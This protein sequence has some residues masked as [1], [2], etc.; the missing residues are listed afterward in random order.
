MEIPP[1]PT[2]ATGLRGPRTGRSGFTLAELLTVIALL[3]LLTSL[4]LVAFD[5][6]STT[7]S[8]SSAGADLRDLIE[9]VRTH[10]MSRNTYGWLTLTQRGDELTL[11]PDISR[12]RSGQWATADPIALLPARR[13]QGIR[14]VTLGPGAGRPSVPTDAQIE[15]E[16]GVPLR[17]RFNPRGEVNLE[18]TA[19]ARLLEIGL[20]QSANGQV[21]RVEDYAALQL[22][23]LTGA[24]SLYRP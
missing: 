24:A 10:A 16:E 21:R 1:L 22:R 18:G 12:N 19:P 23:G 14:V 11:T 6:L 20:Q 9:T 13:Q 17:L 5:R 7:R 8:L 3:L 2:P 15:L 4:S